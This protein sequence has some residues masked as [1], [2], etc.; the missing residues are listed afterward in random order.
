MIRGVTRAIRG[1]Q[2]RFKRSQEL[3]RVTRGISVA[4]Q[5]HFI[6]TQGVS[7]NLRKS[8]GCSIGFS[9]S[10]GK[11]SGV[12]V[13]YQ[14]IFGSQVSEV[15]SRGTF[16]IISGRFK[17]CSEVRSTDSVYFWNSKEDSGNFRGI[18]GSLIGSFGTFCE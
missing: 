18:S 7:E 12:H 14:G 11:I 17:E 9:K 5:V 10:L 8:Q 3:Q 4:S 16:S 1:V 2:K 13:V 6:G 15:S